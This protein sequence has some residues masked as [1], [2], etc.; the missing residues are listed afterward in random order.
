[1]KPRAGVGLTDAQGTCELAVGELAVELE[2]H[3]LALAKR[4]GCERITHRRTTLHALE[5]ISR[6]P[7]LGKILPQAVAASPPPSTQLIKSGVAS[8]GKQPR[9]RRSPAIVK[10]RT[11]TVEPLKREC[12][13]ILSRPAITEKG[14]QIPVNVSRALPEES[15]ERSRVENTL[16]GRRSSPRRRLIRRGHESAHHPN[17]DAAGQPI[18]NRSNG[19]ARP[20]GA[21][22][23]PHR[24]QLARKFGTTIGTLAPMPCRTRSS[25]VCATARL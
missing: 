3:E 21:A 8:N 23:H 10:T 15:I 19:L 12:R 2:Q 24:R 5:H 25:V 14:D 1:M 11:R 9:A 7:I 6:R 17:Y 18:T 22:T 16:A 20:I 4:Q 13:R